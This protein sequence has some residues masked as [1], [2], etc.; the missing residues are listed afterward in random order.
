M[1]KW[2]KEVKRHK[3]VYR[4][5]ILGVVGHLNGWIIQKL[6]GIKEER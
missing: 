3:R 2:R 4:V 6:H 1:I 5:Y